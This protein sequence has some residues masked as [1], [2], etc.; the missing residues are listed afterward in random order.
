MTKAA[1]WTII[2][3]GIIIGL[4]CIAIG[5]GVATGKLRIIEQLSSGGYEE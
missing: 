2:V 1:K 3:V 5:I 4:G